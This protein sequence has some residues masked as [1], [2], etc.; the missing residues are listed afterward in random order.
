MGQFNSTGKWVLGDDNDDDHAT[1]TGQDKKRRSDLFPSTGDK[2]GMVNEIDQQH[3]TGFSWWWK[4]LLIGIGVVAAVGAGYYLWSTR[5]RGDDDQDG[6]V[7]DTVKRDSS[8]F[9]H[10]KNK[11]HHHH[12]DHDAD[13]ID[14]PDHVDYH[15]PDLH[16]RTQNQNGSLN[17]GVVV[18]ERSGLISLSGTA[19]A[20]ALPQPH[21]DNARPNHHQASIPPERPELRPHFE[22]HNHHIY[23]NTPPPPAQPLHPKITNLPSLRDKKVPEVKTPAWSSMFS[24]FGSSNDSGGRNGE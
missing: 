11:S 18:A 10:G 23:N 19:L 13:R 5:K 3:H 17:Y 1:R 8:F 6:D 7:A 4:P 22:I 21:Q 16:H 15:N 9:L 20:S 14:I 2:A 24:F 12:D